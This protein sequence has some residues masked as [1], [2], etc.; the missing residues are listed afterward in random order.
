MTITTAPSSSENEF[1]TNE[2]ATSSMNFPTAIPSGNQSLVS[3]KTETDLR[4]TTV[5]TG[6]VSIPSTTGGVGTTSS[7]TAGGVLPTWRAENLLGGLFG[8]ILGL[9][10]L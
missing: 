8:V 2:S 7:S 9:R 1:S 6:T 4:R 3:T 5:L 10:A